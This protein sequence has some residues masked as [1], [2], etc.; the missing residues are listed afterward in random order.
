MLKK[1]LLAIF[2]AAMPAGAQSLE[3]QVYDAGVVVFQ[4]FSDGQILPIC[5]GTAVERGTESYL[6]LSAGHCVAG[7]DQ[8]G[9]TILYGAR[10]FVGPTI[11]PALISEAIVISVGNLKSGKDYAILLTK[12]KVQ[13]MPLAISSA[14]ISLEDEV[15]IAGAPLGLG[16]FLLRGYVAATYMELETPWPEGF[17]MQV[18]DIAGGSSGSGVVCKETGKICGIVVGM[19]RNGTAIA[20]PVR[21]FKAWVYGQ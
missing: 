19:F 21:D 14:S 4:E 16:K 2:L 18:S 8:N 17:L 3:Q 9:Q 13:F 1:L 7:V 20:L 6:I 11:D 5:S 12:P 15:L 10:L